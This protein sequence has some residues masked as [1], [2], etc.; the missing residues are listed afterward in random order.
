MLWGAPGVIKVPLPKTR[1]ETHMKRLVTAALLLLL[2][3]AAA[4]GQSRGGWLRGAWEGTGYQSDSED[5]TTWA[6]RLTVTRGVYAVE[7]PSLECAARW[8]LLSL[9]RT[10]AVFRETVTRGAEKCSQGGRVVLQR[11]NSRQLGYWFSH[12]GS[13]VY[14]ASA[15]LNRRR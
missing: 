1:T 13:A 5:K 8:R 15:I 3:A 7:Y 10:R 11:L 12:K 4:A 6:M 9:S 14:V 2:A